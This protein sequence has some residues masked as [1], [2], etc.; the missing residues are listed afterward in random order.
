M[1]EPLSAALS[2]ATLRP[3]FSEIAKNINKFLSNEF[4]KHYHLKIFL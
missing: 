1:I 2:L 3:I 4:L